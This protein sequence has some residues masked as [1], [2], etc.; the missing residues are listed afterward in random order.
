[1]SELQGNMRDVDR[2]GTGSGCRPGHG[3]GVRSKDGSYCRRCGMSARSMPAAIA[4]SGLRL[5]RR[6]TAGPFAR[7][8]KRR[9]G[10]AAPG[11]GAG[12]A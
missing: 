2:A 1:M 6:R 9:R 5:G 12:R 8:R 11:E 7:P 3:G 10:A 4:V